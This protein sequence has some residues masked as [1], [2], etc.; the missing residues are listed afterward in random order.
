VSNGTTRGI[1]YRQTNSTSDYTYDDSA[2]SGATVYIVDTGIFIEHKVSPSNP[3][4]ETTLT[5]TTGI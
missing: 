1:F 2:G 4:S 3:F 5:T